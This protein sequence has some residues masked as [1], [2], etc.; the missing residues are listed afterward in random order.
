MGIAAPR[1]RE[2]ILEGRGMRCAVEWLI[3]AAEWPFAAAVEW[4]LAAGVD[5]EAGRGLGIF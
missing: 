1:L 3:A 4:P 2:A 5:S